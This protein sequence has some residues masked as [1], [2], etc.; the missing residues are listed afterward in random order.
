MKLSK[1]DTLHGARPGVKDGQNTQARPDTGD[2]P[3]ASVGHRRRPSSAGCRFSSAQRIQFNKTMEPTPFAVKPLRVP[4]LAKN[5]RSARLIVRALA[6][7]SATRCAYTVPVLIT[8]D[9]K[10]AETNLRKHGT[11][12]H[13]AATIFSDPFSTTFPSQ[14]HSE[15]EARFLTIG[16]SVNWNVL[17]VAHTEEDNVIRII[18]ARRA[19]SQERRFYEKG[20]SS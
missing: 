3:R 6:G 9:Q 13:E 7:A 19:T 10:K 11:D 16:L 15:S 8:W 18:S 14:D 20:R 1:R 12:F 4:S 5:A 17:V 2:R